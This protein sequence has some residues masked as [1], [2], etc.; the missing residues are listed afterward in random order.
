MDTQYSTTSVTAIGRQT[1]FRRVASLLGAIFLAVVLI[2]N[3]TGGIS[4]AFAVAPYSIDQCNYADDATLGAEIECSVVVTNN[5]DAATDSG[6][7]T[8]TVEE[9]HGAA[10]TQL[11]CTTSTTR[12]GPIV[13]AVNQCNN[14]VNA[15]GSNVICSVAVTNVIT[16]EF[17]TTPATVNQCIGSGAGG[18]ALPLACSP[19]QSTTS[20]TVTQC[21]RSLNGGGGT[22]RVQC[23][24]A[25]STTMVASSTMSALNVTV[26]QCNDSANGGGSVGICSASLQNSRAVVVTPTPTATAS[27][28]PTPG[29]TTPTPTGT[30]STPT[31]PTDTPSAPST[32]GTP[33]DSPST[34]SATP[35]TPPTSPGGG[36]GEG[37]PPTTPAVPLVPG[38]P[39]TSG[40]PGAPTTPGSLAETGTDDAR[41]L[42]IGAISLLLAG[43]LGV[44][45]VNVHRHRRSLR[46]TTGT[47]L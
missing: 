17:T 5:Y 39:G 25:P 7:S 35:T 37:T 12:G 47:E 16:G 20:A 26:N 43:A 46:H 40:T 21:N 4:P 28:T 36:N 2:W 6:T 14:S 9:C 8:V 1:T 33:T 41:S 42:L 31:I 29:P 45:A 24:V 27:A 15:P 18:G 3:W 13:T 30:P 38:T 11:A 23:T 34:P 10:G 32:P 44:L 19:T 22:G